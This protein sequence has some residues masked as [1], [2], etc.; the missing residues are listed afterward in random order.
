MSQAHPILVSETQLAVDED[1]LVRSSDGQVPAY[2]EV[3]RN[4]ECLNLLRQ[5]TYREEYDYS[6]L[7]AFQGSEAQVMERVDACVQRLRDVITCAGD[8]TP[9]LIMLTPEK[10]QKESPDFE[11]LHYCRD[12]DAILQWTRDNEAQDVDVKGYSL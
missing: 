3:F 8:A 11:T 7:A 2:L 9:Y 10:A 12:F 1:T 4:M 6:S 5:H